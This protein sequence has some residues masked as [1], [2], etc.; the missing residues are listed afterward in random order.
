ML[1]H[2]FLWNKI[3]VLSAITQNACALNATMT[4]T[5]SATTR[6]FCQISEA[7]GVREICLNEPKTRNALSLGMM[8]EILN[9]LKQTW[10]DTN[11]RCIIISSTGPIWSSGHDLKELVP[12]RSEEQQRAVFEKLTEIIYNI[13]KAPVPVLAKVNGVVAAGGVQLVASCDII[14]CSEKSSFITPSAN[15]GVFASTPAVAMTRV[16]SH[17]KCLDMLMTGHP[18]S[19]R[20]AYVQGMVS[21]VVPNEELDAEIVKIVD[22]IKHKSR[23]VLALGKEFFYQQ[24]ELTLDEAYKQGAKKMTENLKLNDS[25][26]GLRSFMEKRKPVWSHL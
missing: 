15:F 18:I 4:T 16:M 8:N 10:E 23:S 26:E 12:E 25:K 22:A 6:Q 17:S 1:R 19:A 13:R 9:A 21:R 2:L 5:T 3:P 11:L 20:E 14:V 24:L 7:N